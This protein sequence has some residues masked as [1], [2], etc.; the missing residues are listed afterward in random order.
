MTSEIKTGN[1]SRL[2]WILFYGL[3]AVALYFSIRAFMGDYRSNMLARENL[4]RY[5]LRKASQQVETIFVSAD[6]LM[7]SIAERYEFTS[8]ADDDLH[9]LM[10]DRAA[11]LPMIRVFLIVGADGQVL[12][13][14]R[15]NREAVGLN[16][17]DRQ[18]FAAHANGTETGLFIGPPVQS[19][20]DGRWAMPISRAYYGPDGNLAFVVVTSLRPEYFETVTLSTELLSPTSS[21]EA[22]YK[23][24]LTLRDGTILSHAPHPESFISRNLEEFMSDELERFPA[25][26]ITLPSPFPAMRGG[27]IL[28]NSDLLSPLPLRFF[29]SFDSGTILRN[30]SGYSLLWAALMLVLLAFVG[31]LIK[32]LDTHSSLLNTKSENLRKELEKR[33]LAEKELRL[34]R[35]FFQAAFDQSPLG[36]SIADAPDGKIRY[37]NRAGIRIQGESAEELDDDLG[38][39]DYTSHWSIRHPDGTD[40]SPDELPLTRALFKGELCQEEMIITQPGGQQLHVIANAAPVY[41]DSGEIAHAVVI[42]QDVT[43]LKQ[44][45]EDL[46]IQHSRMNLAVRAAGLGIW[47]WAIPSNRLVWNDRMYE[48]YGIDKKHHNEPVYDTW[49]SGVHEEDRNDSSE[50]IQKALRGEAP[51]DTR[52]RVVQQ[53]GTVKWIKSLAVVIFGKNNEP[54]KM[55]GIN[56]DI[57]KEQ[58]AKEQLRTSLA[59]KEVLL[60]ELYHRTKNTLQVIR[61]M[62]VLQAS[63]L[64]ESPE[65]TRLVSST[66]KRILS[67]AL[68]HKK[69]YQSQDLS[70]INF[71]EYITEL[72]E[73]IIQT[74][75]ELA[76]QNPIELS[77]DVQALQ[78]LIDTAIPCGIILNELMTNSIQHGFP[79]MKDARIS[80]TLRTLTEDHAELLYSDNGVGFTGSL[81]F[82]NMETLGL[83][84]I[85]AIAEQQLQGEIT[86]EGGD[87]MSC[88]ISFPLDTYGARI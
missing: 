58:I 74:S 38:V 50:L 79:E 77:L 13:D 27:V 39:T 11:S 24:A 22:A 28:L 64:G 55:I 8:S 82:A 5:N 44:I 72:A 43:D 84:S 42:F 69:L 9:A 65:I 32:R 29:L 21:G 88:R 25:E 62:L 71:R 15:A 68:V 16:V 59:E 40:F 73:L 61:S 78:V 10:A 18:Y 41:N 6:S 49:L 26:E 12:M 81:D 75:P 1:A 31:I 85:K 63:T 52:F 35:A 20:V 47:E 67:M 56:Q 23:L 51:F 86:F 53:D 37:V 57:T 2:L 7:Q 80:V 48:L 3:V 70:H 45:S 76:D 34:S 33:S 4:L 36:I 54:E 87:G 46:R 30:I 19:R 14:S 60:K 83:Q 66:E 17:Q